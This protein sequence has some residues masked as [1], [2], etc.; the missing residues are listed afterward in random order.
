MPE[1][2]QFLVNEGIDS[3]SFNADA[4]LKGIENMVAAEAVKPPEKTPS[5]GKTPVVVRDHPFVESIPA[6]EGE[7]EQVETETEF[8]K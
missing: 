6:V 1:F 3:I 7:W 8:L 4:L 5:V 2:A